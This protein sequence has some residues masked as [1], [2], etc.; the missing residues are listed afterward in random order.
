MFEEASWN[1]LS[2]LPVG[3]P[4]ERNLWLVGRNAVEELSGVV[5]FGEI[6]ESRRGIE[7]LK[8][9]TV[10]ISNKVLRN[11]STPRASWIER[12]LQEP[13]RLIATLHWHLKQIWALVLGTK[14]AMLGEVGCVGP[15]LKIWGGEDTDHVVSGIRNNHDPSAGWLVP[16][17]IWITEIVGV[18]VEHWVALVG[19]ESV[20]AV[21]TVGNGLILSA[22]DTARIFSE[23]IDLQIMSGTLVMQ[24]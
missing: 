15:F 17:D 23:R 8:M 20:S 6:R 11:T 22:L 2:V 18:D 1:D 7:W 13:D 16:D 9:S 10:E 19:L 24:E 12:N 3:G 21:A 4:S 14:I 5:V